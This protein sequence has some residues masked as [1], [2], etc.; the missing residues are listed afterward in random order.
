MSEV[1]RVL[2]FFGVPLRGNRRLAGSKTANVDT[3]NRK[4]EDVGRAKYQTD[5]FFAL[6][7]ELDKRTN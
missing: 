7:A 2:H 3:P 5:L 1:H 6:T 4:T